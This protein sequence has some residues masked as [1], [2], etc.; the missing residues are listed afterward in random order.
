MSE[1][2]L[3]FVLKTLMNEVEGIQSAALVSREG[4]IVNSILDEGIEPMHIAALAAIILSTCEKVLVELNKGQL[5]VC[6]IQ[7]SEGKF[8]VM[9][10]GEDF[11]LVTVLAEDARMDIAFSKMRASVNKII[12][13]TEDY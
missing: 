10:C 13:L 2:E 5:D 4:L 3:N 12:D 7:G 8:M 1:S 6:I 9:E 11:I